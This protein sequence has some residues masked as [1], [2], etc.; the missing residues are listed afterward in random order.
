[1][2]AQ[3][4]DSKVIENA[5][6]P[7]PDQFGTGG[8]RGFTAL[9]IALSAMLLAVA[10]WLVADAPHVVVANPAAA[11]QVVPQAEYFP[12]RYVNQGKEIEPAPPTF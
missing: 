6:G 12:S 5:G 11:A 9:A 3:D 1:M 4:G 10:G 8:R 2:T 7:A